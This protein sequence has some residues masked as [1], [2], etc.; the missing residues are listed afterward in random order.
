MK[1]LLVAINAKYIHSNLAVYSLA[2]SAK[3]LDVEIKIGEYTINN[4]KDDILAAIYEEKAD[5]VAFSCYIWNIEYVNCIGQELK[6]IAPNISVWVGGPEVSYNYTEVLE[7]KKYV[8]I[9]VIGEGEATFS[10]LINVYKNQNTERVEGLAKV[11]GIAYRENLQIEG[12]LVVNNSNCNYMDMDDLPFVYDQIENFE[13]KIIYY[14][15]SR[16]CPFNCSYCLSS[17]DKR[18]RFRSLVKVYEELQFFLDN[19]V[20]Q[21]KFIDRTFNCSK[22]HSRKIWTYILEHDNGITN[23]HFEV[24]SDLFEEEDFAIFRQMRQGLIQLEIGL[25]STNLE[26]IREVHRVMNIDKLKN[27]LAKIKEMNNI[28]Q[29]LDLI[30]GL[31]YEDYESFKQS[32]N[33]AYDMKPDQLQLGFLKVLK[34]SYMYENRHEYEL[35]Y[36][37]YSPYEVMAT[38]WIDYDEILK[39]KNVEEVLEVYYNSNQFK[40]SLAYLLTV[41]SKPYDFYFE[42]SSYYEEN[43]LFGLQQKRVVRYDILRKYA[44]EKLTNKIDFKLLDEM[45]IIDLYMRENMKTRPEWGVNLDDYKEAFNEFFKNGG[46]KQL[47]LKKDGEDYQSKIVARQMHIERVSKVA[48]EFIIGVENQLIQNST[49]FL[50]GENLQSQENFFVF[51]YEKRSPLTNDAEIIF[52]K[53]I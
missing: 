21:I 16:G 28:H 50:S 48:V 35:V 38:K 47:Q 39:L 12:R 49:D 42:L 51:D 4:N 9:V 11:S 17:I 10:Q 13:N 14:E 29:H 27:A 32:F 40:C 46:N 15:T 24:S 36:H 37:D 34:G 7:K 8:D 45:L 1:I 30:A 19:K 22:E 53:D 25:Q 3:G 6:K 52:L 2:S 43:N 20:P 31:P 5:V 41:F 18:V 23:F 44:R 26:A 33:N